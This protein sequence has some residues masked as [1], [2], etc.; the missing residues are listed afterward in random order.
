MH[1][2]L[3]RQAKKFFDS[4]G[5]VC[6][7]KE[8]KAFL[9]DINT[10]YEHF[11]EDRYLLE[12]SLELSSKELVAI[13][14][15]LETEKAR[16][17][18]ILT[19]VGDGLIV[20]DTERKVLMMNSPAEAM[21][22]W[23]LADLEGKPLSD[24]IPVE[25]KDGHPLPIEKMPL[26]LAISS[27]RKIATSAYFYVRK[28]Q[29]KFPVAITAAPVIMG[30]EAI[31][32]VLIFRDIAKEY[33]VDKAKT[34]FVSLASHQMRT[35]LSTVRW[36]TEMLLADDAGQ[37]NDQQKKYL[38]IVYAS[39]KRMIELIN[40]L[41]NVSRLELG[42][43][44]VEPEPTNLADLA[45]QV[46]KELEHIIKSSQFKIK[47]D[48][49]A[50]LPAIN[51]DPKLMR[52]VFQNLISNSM[53]YTPAG[54][55]IRVLIKKRANDIIMEVADNGY[56]IP[57]Y[58]QSQVFTKLFRADNIKEK[59]S[60]GTGL[61]LY[62]VK[63]IINQAGGTIWFESAENKGTTFYATIPL[64]GMIKKEG[65]KSLT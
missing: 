10:T 22:G 30:R 5:P 17:E 26:H 1:K 58:Q 51:I 53:K 61:G 47:K 59:D 42:T 15:N 48:Y 23:N 40:S 63:S 9:E 18:A 62:I 20:T 31:G 36:Y 41:L 38:E 34:E 4:L 33:D 27:G 16:D 60:E 25:D 21:L 64:E 50:A 43:F 12:R 24:F 35:P 56:G 3:E 2:I 37:L 55:E 28:D 32:G 45:E 57:Q 29:T 6:D 49:D 52:M 8:L 54:G 46:L 13:N 11:D 19:S 39:N 65:N 7:S 14:K 44:A